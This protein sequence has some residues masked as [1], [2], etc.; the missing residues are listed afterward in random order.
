MPREGR[1]AW[2]FP[3]NH[4]Q[5]LLSIAQ[6][7]GIR[8]RK[9]GDLLTLLAR[10]RAP[11]LPTGAARRTARTRERRNQSTRAKEPDPWLVRLD[12][13]DF[14]RLPASGR[15]HPG[16]LRHG[17]PQCDV[18]KDLRAGKQDRR[19]EGNATA[20]A[21]SRGA[22]RLRRRR[23]LEET[24]MEVQIT[25]TRGAAAH[26]INLEPQPTPSEA[27]DGVWRSIEQRT[28]IEV[29]SRNGRRELVAFNAAHV[30]DVSV[31]AV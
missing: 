26:T 20:R 18:W 31:A 9:F 23:R 10:Q 5:V 30:I 17:D 22:E 11:A 12:A 29:V 13:R 2:P 3:T 1:P 8:L 4:A 16:V 15:S 7:P 21:D 28:P 27:I 25:T 19:Y 6:D 14:H 24:L